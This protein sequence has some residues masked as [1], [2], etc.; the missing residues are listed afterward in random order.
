MDHLKGRG[1]S[2][3]P[4]IVWRIADWIEEKKRKHRSKKGMDAI[5]NLQ[6]LYRLKK[7]GVI[8]EEEFREL[9]EKLK[10]QI[11][12]MQISLGHPLVPCFGYR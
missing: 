6:R 3:V 8:S 12:Q 2:T 4:T 11:G 9:K 5:D 1:L 7:R 10:S